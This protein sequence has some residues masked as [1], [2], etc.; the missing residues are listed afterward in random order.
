MILLSS[1]KVLGKRCFFRCESL[2]SVTFEFGSQ[3]SRIGKWAFSRVGLIEIVIPASVE[4]LGAQC[5]SECESL[6][7]VRFESGSKLLGIESE[8]LHEAGWF[9]REIGEGLVE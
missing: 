1:V 6:S 9:G 8:I 5:F 3:L 2:F 7:S 4:I